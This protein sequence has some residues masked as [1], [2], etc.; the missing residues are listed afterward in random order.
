MAKDIEIKYP[1]VIIK[2]VDAHSSASW[3]S[4]EEALRWFEDRNNYACENVGYLVSET[5]KGICLVGRIAENGDWGMLQRIPKKW[6][7]KV[8]KVGSSKI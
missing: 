2:W 6:I 1:I 5:K 4:Q 3:Y 8:I 7:V